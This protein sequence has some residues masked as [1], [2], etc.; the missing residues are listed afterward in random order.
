MINQ[1]FGIRLKQARETKNMTMEELAKAVGITKGTI[2]K[3]ETGRNQAKASV[4]KKISEILNVDFDWLI[5][6]TD[7]CENKD[8]V[9]LN[10]DEEEL[11]KK[12]RKLP[13]NRKD[14]VLKYIDMFYD[15]ECA[16]EDADYIDKRA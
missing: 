11:I 1:T 10:I 12:Y 7:K 13:Q 3:Y 16:A 9:K 5:G 14:D 6:Y 15:E 2:W 4:A 8:N